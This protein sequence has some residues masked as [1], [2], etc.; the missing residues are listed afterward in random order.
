MVG[1]RFEEREQGVVQGA[2]SIVEQ[3]YAS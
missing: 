1:T 2:K 3:Y